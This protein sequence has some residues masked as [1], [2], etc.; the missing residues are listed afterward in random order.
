MAGVLGRGYDGLADRS[1]LG[2]VPAVARP[3]LLALR[4][5]GEV[6][7]LPGLGG[8]SRE[9][10]IAQP[11]FLHRFCTRLLPAEP[12]VWFDTSESLQPVLQ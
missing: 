3:G 5:D 8:D 10:G 11:L 12:P 2:G 1:V 7:A 6:I 9:G 4:R